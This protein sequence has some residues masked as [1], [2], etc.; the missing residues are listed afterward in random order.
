MRVAL[1][2][3]LLPLVQ[4]TIM[5]LT[6]F[7][8]I[9]TVNPRTGEF[10]QIVELDPDYLAPIVFRSDNTAVLGAALAKMVGCLV[11]VDLSTGKIHEG[12]HYPD[13]NFDSLAFDKLTGQTFVI[14]YNKTNASGVSQLYELL[15]DQSLR[16]ICDIP[17]SGTF[18]RTYSSSKHVFFVAPEVDRL[19]TI[20]Q[21]TI[22]YDVPL[23]FEVRSMVHDDTSGVLYV[24]GGNSTHRAI[25]VS[26]DYTTGA[27][28]RTV[29]ESA[30][31]A[32]AVCIDKAGTVAYS[33]MMDEESVQFMIQTLHLS[34]GKA[35]EVTTDRYAFALSEQ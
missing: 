22:L 18:A 34:S 19:L 25:F 31:S 20:Y 12:Q 30:L 32:G 4:G 6:T 11:T 3:S 28:I 33:S 1:L 10:K 17:T 8:G 24:W 23:P 26:L 2:C 29:Y 16:E 5:A 7:F 13:F 15:P 27:P 9:D 21:G 35:S 14:V